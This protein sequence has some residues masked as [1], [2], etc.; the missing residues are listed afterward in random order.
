M[1]IFSRKK[2]ILKNP[3]VLVFGNRYLLENP[4]LLKI[5]GKNFMKILCLDLLREK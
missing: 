3:L 2:A 5:S 1:G 4:K